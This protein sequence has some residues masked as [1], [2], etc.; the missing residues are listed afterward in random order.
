MV[1]WFDLLG[2]PP[3]LVSG[4]ILLLVSIAYGTQAKRKLRPAMLSLQISL[5]TILAS[6]VIGNVSSGKFLPSELLYA[7]LS[8]NFGMFF[9]FAIIGW[10]IVQICFIIRF[11][12]DQSNIFT[13][14]RR[15]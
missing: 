9:S 8:V 6:T 7:F 10:L 13:R 12:N 1:E 3:S 15:S 2:W 4:G 5:I 11:R 14:N